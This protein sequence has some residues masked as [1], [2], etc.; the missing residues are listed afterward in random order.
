MDHQPIT[1]GQLLAQTYEENA[2]DILVHQQNDYED[3]DVEGYDI[4]EH[5]A[6]Q[7]FGQELTDPHE[8]QRFGG[9]RGTEEVLMKPKDFEDKGSASVRRAKDVQNHIFNIDTLFRPFA[10]GGILPTPASL[11]KI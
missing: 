9:A 8:F 7:D 5:N 4:Q 6:A 11:I 3:E 2:R 1:Y 10:V